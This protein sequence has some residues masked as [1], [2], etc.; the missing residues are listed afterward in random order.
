MSKINY[1]SKYNK[2]KKKYLQLLYEN[3]IGGA[4]LGKAGL[5]HFN[6]DKKDIELKDINLLI[7]E[8][9]YS[10]QFIYNGS[11][12]LINYNDNHPFSNPIVMKDGTKINNNI[13][14]PYTVNMPIFYYLDGLINKTYDTAD[15]SITATSVKDI[16]ST[17]V[18]DDTKL[19]E[20]FD[21]FTMTAGKSNYNKDFK[22]I[23]FLYPT[24]PKNIPLQFT[25]NGNLI[26]IK[27]YNKHPLK[28]P[29]ISINGTEYYNMFDYPSGMNGNFIEYVEKHINKIYLN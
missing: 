20:K 7:T 11:T 23:Q 18:P 4:F 22:E 29:I 21:D 2:Y 14:F 27:Y 25:H 10:I 15:L 1:Y 3:K 8:N 9:P 13:N 12:I 28:Q 26:I 16:Q 19:I 24:V 6:R 17:Y 5:V